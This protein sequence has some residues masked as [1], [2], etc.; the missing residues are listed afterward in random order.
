M[1]TK[2]IDTKLDQDHVDEV[3]DFITQITRSAVEQASHA[4]VIAQRVDSLPFREGPGVGVDSLPFREGVGV[5]VE[6]TG[7]VELPSPTKNLAAQRADREAQRNRLLQRA[8]RD[9]L[10]PALPADKFPGL[11]LRACAAVSRLRPMFGGDFCDAFRLTNGNTAVLLGEISGSSGIVPLQIPQITFGVRAL[12]VESPSPSR[13]LTA[14]NRWMCLERASV[15]AIRAFAR[16]TLVVFDHQSDWADVAVAGAESPLIVT[17]FGSTGSVD[18]SGLPLGI[19]ADYLYESKAFRLDVG[20][21]MVMTTNGITNARHNGKLLGLDGAKALIEAG[22]RLTD[23][24]YGVDRYVLEGAVAYA[25]G[26]LSDN[27]TV[28]SVQRLAKR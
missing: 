20:D 21:T 3:D 23:V 17:G 27:A 15:R 26:Q 5:G 24:D 19:D 2:E 9:V 22:A 1:W 8:L 7:Q 4:D 16:L 14:L 28:V 18:V 6:S 25:G 12:L 10:V 11:N 13:A